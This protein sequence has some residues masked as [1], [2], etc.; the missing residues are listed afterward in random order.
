MSVSVAVFA[1]G[2]GSNFQ[3]LLDHDSEDKPYRI[4]LLIT[5]RPG[6]GALERAEKAGVATQVILV[7][8]RPPD[9][10]GL[11]TLEVLEQTGI[12]VILLAGYLRLKPVILKTSY[13]SS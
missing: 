9:A 7:K 2:G 1:S 3:S 10:V 4:D 6:A 8:G 5:D 13:R 12:Q 11:E